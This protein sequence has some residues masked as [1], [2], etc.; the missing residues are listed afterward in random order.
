MKTAELLNYTVS[1]S[2]GVR[3][4][5]GNLF[6]IELE[7][8]G[9]NVGLQDVATRGWERHHENSLRGESIE[10]TTAGAKTLDES[11]KLVTDLFK[12]FKDNKVVFNNSIRTST[13]VHLNF[14]DKPL[15]KAINF[16]ALFTLFEELLQN[17]SGEDRKGNLF[18]MATR[19]AEGIVGVLASALAMGG[20]GSLAGDRY[21][22]GACNLSCLYKFGTLE[23][24]TMK[25]A[26]SAEQVNNW[27][28]ILN[29]M[30][31]YAVEKMESPAK[32][33]VDLSHLGADGLMRAVFKPENRAELLKTFPV[34]GNLNESLMEGA[35]VIQVFAYEFEDAFNEKIDP[36]RLNR[37]YGGTLPVLIKAGAHRGRNHAI[38]KPDGSVWNV[39]PKGDNHIFPNWNDRWWQDGDKV[40]DDQRIEWSEERGRFIVRYPGG[41]IVECNW[42]RH[43]EFGNEGAPRPVRALPRNWMD[44]EQEEDDDDEDWGNDEDFDLEDF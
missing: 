8:E 13:H 30:Y 26:N 20:L 3:E 22:Y 23:V 32:L 35:R 24:R 2:I 28:E 14:S 34:I 37:K 25:G 36:E 43:P 1:Q 40:A 38:Y 16:F 42:A 33:V 31:V 39:Q 41:E 6:G 19:D 7:L 4:H 21:K 10:Y 12:K 29:D 27:L 44:D 11:K 15:K 9:R 17:Y 18:C 5:K